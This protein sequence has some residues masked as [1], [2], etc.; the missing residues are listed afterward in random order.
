M[1]MMIF[2]RM[3]SAGNMSLEVDLACSAIPAFQEGLMRRAKGY[4]RYHSFMHH[5]STMNKS[6]KNT[7]QSTQS[8]SIIKQVYIYIVLTPLLD[9]SNYIPWLM[10]IRVKMAPENPMV[11]PKL[12]QQ[13]V[14]FT[15]I[16]VL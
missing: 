4:H 12:I 2:N 3:K 8:S 9:H 13:T 7:Y 10:T 14:G 1:G 11:P 5:Q 15:S 16:C 6:Q